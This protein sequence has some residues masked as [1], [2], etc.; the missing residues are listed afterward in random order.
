MCCLA[1]SRW[2][3]DQSGCDYCGVCRRRPASPLTSHSVG[4]LRTSDRQ[5]PPRS[6][7]KPR[8]TYTPITRGQALAIPNCHTNNNPPHRREFP[9]MVHLKP[10]YLPSF[11]I[12]MAPANPVSSV[13]LGPSVRQNRHELKLAIGQSS[14]PHSGPRLYLGRPIQVDVPH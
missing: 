1:G 3:R 11:P 8:S 7:T 9:R 5:E 2:S 12:S 4:R 6:L 14:L 10:W 13:R